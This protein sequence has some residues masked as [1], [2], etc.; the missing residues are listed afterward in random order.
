MNVAEIAQELSRSKAWV[1][2]A[3]LGL[4]KEMTAAGAS[5]A[6]GRILPVYAYMYTVLRLC[7]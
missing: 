5:T 4:I 3:R 2:H 1:I 6:D 7:A